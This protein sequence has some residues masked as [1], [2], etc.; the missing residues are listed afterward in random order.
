MFADEFE[1]R[2]V[3]QGFN[4]DRTI[5]ETLEL[6]WELL[7]ILPKNELKRIKE[8]F[9]EQYYSEEINQQFMQKL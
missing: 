8:E 2:Y 7:S 5:S 9:I 3:S 6:G 1:S 4:L